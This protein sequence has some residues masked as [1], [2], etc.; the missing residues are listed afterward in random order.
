MTKITRVLIPLVLIAVVIMAVLALAPHRISRENSS[1]IRGVVTSV[2]QGG[3]KDI[4]FSLEGVRGI[5]YISHSTKK[6]LNAASLGGRLINKKVM[7][8]YVKPRLFTMLSPVTNTIQITELRL[9]DEVIFSE[10]K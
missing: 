4:V 7:I 10:F 8:S 6:D 2:K 5:Y 1:E 9:G 3:L